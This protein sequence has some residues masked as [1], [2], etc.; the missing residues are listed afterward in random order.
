MNLINIKKI[1]GYCQIKENIF[2]IRNNISIYEIN[3]KLDAKV[4]V[5]M[6][7]LK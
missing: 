5:V 4:L 3:F 6:G 1:K 7:L 2:T